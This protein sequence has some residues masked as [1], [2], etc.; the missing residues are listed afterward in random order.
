MPDKPGTGR[1]QEAFERYQAMRR[2]EPALRRAPDL[3]APEAAEALREAMAIIRASPDA[4][5][6]ELRERLSR[7]SA[8]QLQGD[9]RDLRGA[10]R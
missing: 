9:R 6:P 10:P 7:L 2:E 4:G 8:T 5:A 3:E 1:G